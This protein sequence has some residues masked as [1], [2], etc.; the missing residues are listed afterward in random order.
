MRRSSS[1][2]EPAK[3]RLVL[4]KESWL[5]VNADDELSDLRHQLCLIPEFHDMELCRN[6]LSTVLVFVPAAN[7][8]Q[9]DRLKAVAN[10]KLHGW[11]IIDEQSYSLP[12]TF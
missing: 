4:L 5:P 9:V 8:R 11:K 2:P 12:T 1:H 6:G 7:K 10:E 3:A